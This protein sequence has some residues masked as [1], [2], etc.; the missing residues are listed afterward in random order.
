MISTTILV[1][2]VFGN[3]RVF[4]FSVKYIFEMW[5]RNSDQKML[6]LRTMERIWLNTKK[7]K[8]KEMKTNSHYSV[9]VY[10]FGLQG[11]LRHFLVKSYL[12]CSFCIDFFFSHLAQKTTETQT[13][14]SLNGVN[15]NFVLLIKF[16][17]LRNLNN[18][19]QGGRKF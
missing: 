6:L 15:G 9:Y 10:I 18:E 3:R 8:T 12:R 11:I 13:S 1:L 4:F 16:C 2:P 7:K 17:A 5:Y 14:I 19:S